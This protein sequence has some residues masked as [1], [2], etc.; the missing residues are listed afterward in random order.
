MYLQDTRTLTRPAHPFDLPAIMVATLAATGRG[1]L[2]AAYALDRILSRRAERP[3]GRLG[4]A[5]RSH[6]EVG[7]TDSARIR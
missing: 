4:P 5:M 3:R 1:A 6:A 2:S 7:A